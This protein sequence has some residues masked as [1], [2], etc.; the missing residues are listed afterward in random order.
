MT[1]P[2][3]AWSSELPLWLLGSMK[4]KV[5]SAQT[6]LD[7]FCGTKLPRRSRANLTARLG[8][9]PPG[10]ID[11]IKS[12]ATKPTMGVGYMT[13]RGSHIA[14]YRWFVCHISFRTGSCKTT[15]RM[16]ADGVPFLKTRLEEKVAES[17]PKAAFYV[18]VS[19]NLPSMIAN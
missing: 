6:L 9:C 13:N 1:C 17:K 12:I 14:V 19:K 8:R 16:D 3:M 15:P 10:S 18:G 7:T 2:R 11:V 5:A 4:P